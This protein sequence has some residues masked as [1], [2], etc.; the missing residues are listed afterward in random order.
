MFLFVFDLQMPGPLNLQ[1]TSPLVSVLVPQ[2]TDQVPL[3]RQ[4]FR[5]E[6]LLR[7]SLGQVPLDTSYSSSYLMIS[8]FFIKLSFPLNML[9][10]SQFF[11]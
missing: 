3:S 5:A 11:S 1:L 8:N 10:S 9:V 6:D 4:T 2:R 7:T